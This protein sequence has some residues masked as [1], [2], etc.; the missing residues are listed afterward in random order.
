EMRTVMAEETALLLSLNNVNVKGS[1]LLINGTL[2]DYSLHLGSGV[3]HKIPGGYLSI[4]P[5]H[6]SHRGRIFL[7]FADNDPKTSEILS[8]MLLLAEDGKI[9]D[10]TILRQL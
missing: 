3:V 10:P 8:K 7:P 2:G 9:Q 6:S 1:H 5:V 4:L